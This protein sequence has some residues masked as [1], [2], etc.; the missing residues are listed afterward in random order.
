MG[1]SRGVPMP[2]GI[3]DWTFPFGFERVFF[4]SSL[5]RTVEE[6]RRG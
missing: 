5:N 2:H 6:I 4:Y 1:V 3:G